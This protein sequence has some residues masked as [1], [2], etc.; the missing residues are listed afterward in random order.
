[1]LTIVNALETGISMFFRRKPKIQEVAP[2]RPCIEQVLR[3][4]R[5]ERTFYDLYGRPA[6]HD[7]ARD[8]RVISRIIQTL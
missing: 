5:V 1:V 7:D 4:Q 6:R 3:Q 2:Q 8:Q